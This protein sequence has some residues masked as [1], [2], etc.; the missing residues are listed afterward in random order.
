MRGTLDRTVV[1]ATIERATPMTL[2]VSNVRRRGRGSAG[3]PGMAMFT[4]SLPGET[5]PLDD[6]SAS[7]PRRRVPVNAIALAGFLVV[8]QGVGVVGALYTDTSRGSWYDGLEKPPFMPPS[9][10]FPVAWTAIYALLALGAWRVWRRIGPEPDRSRALVVFGVQLLLNA[11][12][13]P[14]FFGA[15]SPEL[16]LLVIAALWIAVLAMVLTFAP[17]DPLAALVNVPYLGW[18][19]FAAVLNAAIIF[20]Q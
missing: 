8:C 15:E 19:T 10:A 6:V 5:L 20:L 9:W 12:W 3:G 2:S 14:I 11:L 13:T 7:A 16:A 18:V 1:A 4:R 17:V